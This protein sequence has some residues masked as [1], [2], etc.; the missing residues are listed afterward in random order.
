MQS[1]VKSESIQY[2]VCNVISE[3]QREI[4]LLKMGMDYKTAMCTEL[5]EQK[6]YQTSKLAMEITQLKEELNNLVK[7]KD[8]WTIEKVAL[9]AQVDLYKVIKQAR[10]MADGANAIIYTLES[11]VAQEIAAKRQRYSE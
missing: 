6:E 3:Y 9:L 7:Q 1:Q 5:Q 8:A 11:I 2:D 4:E 10:Q